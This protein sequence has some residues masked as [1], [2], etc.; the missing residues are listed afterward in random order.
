MEI[1][2]LSLH[3]K[4]HIISNTQDKLFIGIKIRCLER[5]EDEVGMTYDTEG[6]DSTIKHQHR[7]S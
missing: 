3:P 6:E 1:P 2:F 7:A 4:F 5:L